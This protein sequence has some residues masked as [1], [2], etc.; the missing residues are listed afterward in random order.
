MVVKC[1]INKGDTV[2]F[3]HVGSRVT[4]QSIMRG[5]VEKYGITSWYHETHGGKIQVRS[6]EYFNRPDVNSWSNISFTYTIENLTA[7]DSGRYFA[8]QQSGIFARPSVGSSLFLVVTGKQN[9]RKPTFK[10]TI[11]QRSRQTDNKSL[12]NRS[13]GPSSDAS[14]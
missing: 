3:E 5:R 10:I 2:I 4:L 7:M 6:S 8:V 13:Q 9:L 1:W 11:L 14:V 12:F